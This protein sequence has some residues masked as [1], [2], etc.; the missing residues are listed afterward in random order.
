MF[1]LKQL[2]IRA[3]VPS[4]DRSA[5]VPRRLC[6]SFGV[7]RIEARA[8][9]DSSGPETNSKSESSNAPNY[10]GRS[11]E[12]FALNCRL[13]SFGLV[14]DFELRISDLIGCARIT[15]TRVERP[16]PCVERA[17]QSRRAHGRETV[18][19][20]SLLRTC[21]GGPTGRAGHRFFRSSPAGRAKA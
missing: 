21:P 3:T 15:E 14:S 6:H 7:I 5:P 2:P 9:L 18:F 17:A 10:A 1:R 4:P 16:D 8:W 13:R 20:N 12:R 11:S 19:P